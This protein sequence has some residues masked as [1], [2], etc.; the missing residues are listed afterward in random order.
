M[1]DTRNNNQDDLIKQCWGCGEET[2]GNLSRS[3]TSPG[4]TFAILAHVGFA[5]MGD[6]A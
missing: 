5:G 4:L 1:H 3:P 6:I 2:A